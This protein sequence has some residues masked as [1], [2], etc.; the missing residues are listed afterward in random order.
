MIGLV[1]ILPPPAHHDGTVCLNEVPPVPATGLAGVAVLCGRASEVEA[2]L[3]WYGAVRAIRPAFPMGLVCWPEDSATA[4]GACAHPV[5]PVIR[6]GDL[7]AGGL[8]LQSLDQLR[9]ASVEGLILQEMTLK[10]GASVQRE[11][12]LLQC[13]VPPAVRGGSLRRVARDCGVSEDT[14][15]R[16]LRALGLRCGRLMSWVRVRG[17]QLHVELGVDRSTALTI[18]NWSSHDARRKTARRVTMT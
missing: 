9:A 5:N 8:P 4:L 1:G 16:R 6:P 12:A 14:V 2:A 11:R 17:F 13:L 10:Y 15:Q 3:S 7:H 18:G